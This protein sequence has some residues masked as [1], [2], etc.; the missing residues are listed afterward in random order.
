MSL[1]NTGSEIEDINEEDDSV[2]STSTTEDKSV[3]ARILNKKEIA[4]FDKMIET[5][6]DAGI[7]AQ[8]NVQ[9]ANI[10]NLKDF[11]EDIDGDGVL[12]PKMIKIKVP[13]NNKNED[14]EIIEVPLFSLINHNTL[15][16]DN[17][18]V[19]FKLNLDDMTVEK[20]D[21]EHHK[22]MKTSCG[23]DIFKKIWRLRVNK[24]IKQNANCAE[25]VV[26]FKYDHPLE[27][28]VRLSERY[29]RR[30]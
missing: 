11:F 29:S 3:L 23:N 19:K 20:L 26:D 15:K 25:I 4:T 2:T 21:K 12:E 10:H 8:R 30:I 27:S 13:S 28:I 24:P 22:K 9:M 5:L 18:Q 17:L 1:N 6:Y 14:W 16:I 7:K